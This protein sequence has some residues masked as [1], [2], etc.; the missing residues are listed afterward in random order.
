M[1]ALANL[2]IEKGL[3]T[4]AEFHNK[5]REVMLEYKNK[6]KDKGVFFNIGVKKT[7]DAVPDSI[8]G[9]PFRHPGFQ[10]KVFTVV[11]SI[12]Q[13]PQD[14]VVA[15]VKRGSTLYTPDR[16]ASHII[17]NGHCKR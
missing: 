11:E 9:N 14:H 1:D 8:L 7:P 17:L 16:K 4:E 12:Q 10:E 13:Q 15:V 2:L 5:L 3:I 6:G